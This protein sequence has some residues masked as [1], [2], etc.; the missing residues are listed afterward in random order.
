MPG[1]GAS[2][3]PHRISLAGYDGS[4]N[5]VDIREGRS[6]AAAARVNAAAVRMTGVSADGTPSIGAELNLAAMR[7]QLF[8]ESILAWSLTRDAFQKAGIVRAAVLKMKLF[9]GRSM[10]DLFVSGHLLPEDVQRLIAESIEMDA[11][12]E[13]SG[14]ARSKAR[15][16][17][18]WR[19]EH[20]IPGIPE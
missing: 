14:L 19:S 12:Y 2:S 16:S 18:D 11:A 3:R 9:D 15:P 10:L 4:D 5:W 20:S 6:S 13:R 17:D 7:L 8:R 1:Y